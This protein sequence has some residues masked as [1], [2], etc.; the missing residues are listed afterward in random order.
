MFVAFVPTGA[1]VITVTVPGEPPALP[2]SIP[3]PLTSAD[4][5]ASSDAAT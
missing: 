1:Q 2:G 5:A 3:H 4:T